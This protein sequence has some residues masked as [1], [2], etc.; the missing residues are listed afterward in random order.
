MNPVLG[1]QIKKFLVVLKPFRSFQCR[2]SKCRYVFALDDER[3]LFE[4][5]LPAIAERELTV[6]VRTVLIF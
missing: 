4:T 5:C 3:F 2:R 6:S 1:S